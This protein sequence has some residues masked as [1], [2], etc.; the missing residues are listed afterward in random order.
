[1]P[2]RR[3][4]QPTAF[5]SLEGSAVSYVIVTPDSLAATYQVLRDF[6]TAKACRRSCAQ[7]SRIAAN[8][9]NGSDIQETIRTFVKD[10]YQ[11]WG[12]T[13]VLSRRLPRKCRRSRLQQ[14]LQTAESSSRRTCTS[15][16]STATGMPTTTTCSAK[17]R[18]PASTI[19]TVCRGVCGPSA[20][21]SATEAAMMINK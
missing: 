2:K 19:P 12:I 15:A 18:P 11:K 8:Y 10:A 13:Y 21:D 14:F 4:F 20:V 5:P 7:P 3:G 6:K 9:R 16:A 17:R 1:V